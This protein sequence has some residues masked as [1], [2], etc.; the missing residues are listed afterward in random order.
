MSNLPNDQRT[1]TLFERGSQGRLPWTF[2]LGASL[3]YRHSFGNSDLA[4]KFSVYNLL[5]QQ[6]VTEVNEDLELEDA[7]GSRNPLFLQGTGYQAARYGQITVSLG[8]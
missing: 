3:T 5:N 1:Y 2:D 6:K 8:F 4:V 7:I